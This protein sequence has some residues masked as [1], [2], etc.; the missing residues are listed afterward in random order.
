MLNNVAPIDLLRGRRI[1]VTGAEGFLGGHLLR[2]LVGAGLDV[3]AT[4]CSREAAR[5]LASQ[6]HRVELLDLASDGSWDET[7]RDCDVVFAVAGLF[8][9]VEATA[10]DYHKVNRVGALNLVRAAARAGVQRFVHCSTAGVHGDVLEI[11]ATETTPVNPM[12]VY[13]RSKL[14]GELA[15]LDYARSLPA[16]GM[17]VTVNRPAM[18][19]GPGDLRMLKLF[20]AVLSGRF[21]MVGSGRTLSHLGYIE[22]QTDSFV[23]CAVAARGRVHGEAFNIA[24]DE[25]LSLNALTSL[26]ADCGGVDLRRWSVPV[27]P[28]WLAAAAC[29]AIYRPLGKRPPLFRRRVG[30][31]THNR[32][33]DLGKAERRLHYLSRRPRRHRAIGVKPS[34]GGRVSLGLILRLAVSV[35]LLGYVVRLVAWRDVAARWPEMSGT[36]LLLLLLMAP[37]SVG[38]SV[39]KWRILLRS[40]GARVPSRRL[41][42]LYVTGQFYSQVLPSSVG[43]DVVRGCLLQRELSP[44]TSAFASIFI[45][46]LTGLVSLVVL[47]GT[48]V[49][50]T[51]GLRGDPVLL[52]LTLLALLAAAGLV[53]AAG[54][55]ACGRLVG[56]IAGERPAARRIVEKL[57]RF[58]ASLRVY[59]ER[60]AVLAASIVLSFA[61]YAGTMCAFYFAVRAAGYDLRFWQVAVVVPVAQL[62]AMLPISL[63][64]IGMVEWV[65]TVAF[66]ALGLPP[67]AGLSAALLVR[68]RNVVWA[69][70]GY[71]LVGGGRVKSSQNVFVRE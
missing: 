69:A 3:K 45:E 15:V 63:N 32:A 43:G 10:D 31:F 29:E 26:I 16:D 68:V 13:Q 2:R 58:H 20:H 4:V 48:A 25:P 18:V 21:V 17:I 61:F 12:D 64:G 53:V 62:A 5:E 71:A 56:R 27:A 46:R 59:R 66:G 54:L 22:D 34:P 50:A 57:E 28:V 41:F 9:E 11:P 1:V 55:P 38:L 37:V 35:A 39:W 51:P 30:F 6:G 33:F 40:R 70:L 49:A 14:A 65:F 24:S 7:L 8:Q 44:E 52:G 19:Y 60:P 23:L 67:A 42:G 36:H 47:G